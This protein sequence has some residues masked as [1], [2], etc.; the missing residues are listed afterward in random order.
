MAYLA[1]RSAFAKGDIGPAQGILMMV[2]P[3]D[4][5]FPEAQNLLGVIK[6]QQGQH[7]SAI[8]PLQIGYQK[9][10][11]AEKPAKFQDAVLINMARAY[12]GAKNYPQASVYYEQIPRS[13]SYWLDAVRTCMGTLSHG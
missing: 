2:K 12:F 11:E 8:A 10:L 9:G 13:S 3:T 7:D 4:P 1:A 5:D 6:S